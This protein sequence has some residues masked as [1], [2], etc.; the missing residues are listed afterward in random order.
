MPAAT[1]LL[2]VEQVGPVIVVTLL[3]NNTTTK[4]PWGTLL[5][6]HRINPPLIGALNDALDSALAM[7]EVAAVVVTNQ[8]KFFSNGL[9]L[10]WIDQNPGAAADA[11]QESVE[12]LLVRLLTFPVPTGTVCSCSNQ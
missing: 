10:K 7:E 12:R 9:D 1:D 3:G 11:M 2:S 6:E 5:S 8:G 4:F